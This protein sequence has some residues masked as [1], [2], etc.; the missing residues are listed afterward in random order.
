MRARQLYEEILLAEPGHFDALHLLGVAA[1]AS[2]EF[3][4]AVELIGKAIQLNPGSYIAHCNR[5]AALLDCGQW[6][7][8][9]TSFDRAI[10]LNSDYADAHYNRGKALKE[11]RRWADALASCDRAI[12]LDPARP[13]AHLIRGIVLAELRLPELAIASFDTAIRLEGDSAA[14]YWNRANVLCSQRRWEPALEGYDPRHRIAAGLCRGLGRTAPSRSTKCSASMNRCRAAIAPSRLSPTMSRRTAIVAA[15]W[16]RR[17]RWPGRSRATIERSRSVPSGRR[18]MRAGRWRYCLRETTREGWSENEWRWKDQT[19]WLIRE[20]RNFRQ[21]KWLGDVSPSGKTIFLHSE[22]GFGDT[23]QFCRYVPLVAQLGARI[24]LEVPGPLAPL[25]ARLS[26]VSQIVAQGESPPPFDMFCPLLSLPLALRTTL[27]GVPGQV[28]YLSAGEARRR[29]WRDKLGARTRP[30]IGLVWSGGFRAN[31]PELWLVNE[32]RNI[33]LAKFAALEQFDADFYSLQKG[34]P[35]E[36]EFAQVLTRGW[37]GPKIAS[38]AGEVGDFADSAAFIEQLDLVISV[39]T[40]VAHLAGALAKPVWILNRFDACWRWLLD[41]DDSPWYPTA[42]LY[43]QERPGDWDFGD[44]QSHAR[45]NSLA[46]PKITFRRRAVGLE[47]RRVR[48]AIL[49][50]ANRTSALADSRRPARA[51]CFAVARDS[52]A[53]AVQLQRAAA[54]RPH[55]IAGR[56]L[57]G[58]GALAVPGAGR[59]R[60]QPGGAFESQCG[61]SRA[62]AGPPRP[63]NAAN[64][65]SR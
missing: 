30:R 42:R 26:G 3:A 41:R 57:P 62:A 25:L 2:G 43:R 35:A 50:G 40:A 64:E 34:E 65:R 51:G 4:R 55:R 46:R 56:R 7:A 13:G 44:E 37:N 49:P 52:P 1:S 27:S 20:A 38:L 6:R 63:W 32:R 58:R 10:A 8:A 60:G 16:L 18:A 28:P 15:C 54:A 48:N 53:R 61:P 45:S 21:P 47:Q 31:Q 19:G 12:S 59:Q 39:D 24:I 36:S 5:G 22:Q 17:G 11:L 23:I 14:A 29:L 9:V 33:P